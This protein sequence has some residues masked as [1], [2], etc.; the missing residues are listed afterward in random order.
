MEFV[1]EWR[2]RSKD[3]KHIPPRV[4]RDGPVLENIQRGKD[5]NILSFLCRAG[6][7]WTAA[8]TSA[9]AA[10]DYSQFCTNTNPVFGTARV[11]IHDENT[12]GF[13]IAPG[14]ARPNSS[15]QGVR[16]RRTVQSRDLSRDTIPL[17]FFTGALEVPYGSL[18]VLAAFSEAEPPLT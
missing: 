14:T 4:V 3:L 12:V 11:I 16:A 15:R 7:S 8:D 5:V 17:I 6:S 10:F 13:Y 2:R 1:S 9:P 18:P